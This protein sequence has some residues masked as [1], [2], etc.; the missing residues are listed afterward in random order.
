MYPPAD[1]SAHTD[2]ETFELAEHGFDV[3]DIAFDARYARHPRTDSYPGH[4]TF[5][6]ERFQRA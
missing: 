4:E 5:R 2:M 6:P 3:K 1:G